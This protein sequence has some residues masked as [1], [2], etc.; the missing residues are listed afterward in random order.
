ME[1]ISVMITFGFLYRVAIERMQSYNCQVT[2]SM[3]TNLFFILLSMQRDSFS[4]K[5]TPWPLILGNLIRWIP[6]AIDCTMRIMSLFQWFATFSILAILWTAGMFRF[7]ASRRRNFFCGRTAV[8]GPPN[9]ELH[10]HTAGVLS[11]MIW[12][13]E[14]LASYGIRIRMRVDLV[15]LL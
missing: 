2:S 11:Y 4:N 9:D 12:I 8:C 10:L 3:A 6:R 15:I 14:W 1:T 13:H 5:M 7:T